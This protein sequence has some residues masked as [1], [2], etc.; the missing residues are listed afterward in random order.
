MAKPLKGIWSVMARSLLIALVC[1]AGAAP[2]S[3]QGSPPSAATAGSSNIKKERT[4]PSA[5]HPARHTASAAG[6][7]TDAEHRYSVELPKGFVVQTQDAAALSAFKPAPMA[8]FFIMNP[9]MAAGAL[10]GVEPPDLQVRIFR[11]AG[12]GSVQR[13]LVASGLL[14]PQA[15]D[16]VQPYRTEHVSGIRHCPP[17]L[18]APGCSV[19]VLAHDQV[20]QLAAATR[21]GEAM[22]GSFRLLP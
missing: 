6:T 17:T 8:A 19:Y 2:V 11:A 14:A 1:E 13:W 9:T 5:T 21:E 10:A 16:A 18:I 12:E 20:Y 22:L 15:A 4:P 3:Q 7:Y